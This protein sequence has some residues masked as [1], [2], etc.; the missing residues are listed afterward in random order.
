LDK[1]WKTFPGYGN[2][3]GLVDRIHGLADLPFFATGR[4]IVRRFFLSG[5]HAAA[6]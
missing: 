5:K 6:V 1:S 4:L 2:R 3:S